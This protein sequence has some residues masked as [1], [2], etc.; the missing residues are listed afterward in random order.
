MWWRGRPGMCCPRGTVDHSCPKLLLE[1]RVHACHPCWVFGLVRFCR[2]PVRK[3]SQQSLDKE[4]L[5]SEIIKVHGLESMAVPDISTEWRA[6]GHR[7]AIVCLNTAFCKMKS[8]TNT[9]TRGRLL[10]SCEVLLRLLLEGAESRS[11]SFL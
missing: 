4:G 5:T 2:P 6:T 9:D 1:A 3:V 11:P 10:Q 7:E 8:S